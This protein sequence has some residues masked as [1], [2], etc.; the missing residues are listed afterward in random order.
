LQSRNGC[1]RGFRYLCR[2]GALVRPTWLRA[3]GNDDRPRAPDPGSG[4]T[5]RQGDPARSAGRG[6]AGKHRS[7]P[8]TGRPT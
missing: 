1:S 5:V 2:F 3:S 8:A 7:T 6:P 4:G